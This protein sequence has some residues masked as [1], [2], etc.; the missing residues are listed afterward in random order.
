MPYGIPTRS[1]DA[2]K[3]ALHRASHSHRFTARRIFI[4][5]A[6]IITILLL[7]GVVASQLMQLSGVHAS[8]ADAPVPFHVTQPA[9]VQKSHVIG[10]A[11]SQQ[12]ISLAIGLRV[13]NEQALQAYVQD[14]THAGSVNY[15][16]Y[17][18]PAQYIGAFSPSTALYNQLEQFLQAQG[19]TVTHTYNHRLLISFSGTIAQVERTFSVNI[20]TYKAPDGHSYYANDND[21]L[22]PAWLSGNVESFSGLDDAVQLQHPLV[23]NHA[24]KQAS[25]KATANTVTCLGHDPNNQY[26]TSDQIASAYN[27][28]GMYNAGYHGEG[29]AIA[30]YEL[31]S[32]SMSD[33][34]TYESCYGHSHTNIQTFVT[35]PISPQPSNDGGI[36]EVQLDAELILSAAPQIGRLAIYEAGNNEADRLAE[37]AQIVNDA[38]PVVSTSWGLC[39]QLMDPQEIRQENTLFMSAV[40][41]GQN[42]F[43]A[44]GDSGSAGCAFDGSGIGTPP[45]GLNAGDPGAQPYVTSVG[46]TTLSLSNSG[47]YSGETTWNNPP[48]TS[49]G[50]S[51]GASG[52]GISSYWTAP[53]WQVGPGVDNSYSSSSPCAA[54]TNSSNRICR[55]TPDVSLQADPTN[56]YLVY[57]TSVQA[58][59]SGTQPW[60]AVGGTSAAAPLWAAMM[61][62]T[63]EISLQ[64]GGFNLGF[65]N[66]LMY[67][68]GNTAN[69][70]ATSFHDITSGNNDYNHLNNGLYPTTANYDMATGLGSYNALTLA[71]NLV[72]ISRSIMQARIS[73]TNTT[74]YF[75][76]GSVGG[77]FQEYITLQ[78]PSV[79]QDA[80]VNITYLFENKSAVTVSHV[81]S[82]S[83]R[84]TVSVNGDLHVQATDP[85][86]AL[87]TI[88][89]VQSGGPGIVAERPM[90]FNYKGIASGTDVVGATTPQRTYYFPSVDARNSGRTY[91]PY[92]TLLNPSSSQSANVSVTYYT[93][94]CGLS[95][96][97]ACPTQTVTLAPLHRGT[98]T[99]M[100]LNLYQQV[101]ASVQSDQA[102]V[103]E[104]PMY[105]SDNIPNAGG[106]TTGAASEVGATS[107][108]TD[109]LF[110]EGYSGPS[111]QEYLEL[112]NFGT[113]AT[114]ATV[115]L[116]YSN[117]HRQ[118]IT[119]SVPALSH[120]YFDVNQANSS[121]TGTCDTSPCQT[122]TTSSAEVTSG[123]PIVV[124]RLMYFHYG[125]GR[126]SGGTETVG[127]PGPASHSVYAFAEGYTAGSFQ[128]YLTLQNPTS[129]DETVAVTLFT[130][131]YILQQ[132]V[133]VKARSRQTVFINP[134]V[135]PI[136]TAYR[137]N[138]SDSFD[139]SLT[140]QAL[141][142]GA[143]IVAER[144]MYFN[145]YGDQ[146][147]TN[148]LGYTGG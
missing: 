127:E 36:I 104:R 141:G 40:A 94:S 53:S 60:L 145:Y 34:T 107:P 121:P 137:N 63:N 129:T 23:R 126:I 4:I 57:C 88:V 140:V 82:K 45:Q 132:Q 77:G 105:F 101:A 6:P 95:N 131:N 109:W 112:A 111:F 125:S 106:L 138:G 98:A 13:Q 8:S 55:E 123:S 52:G 122:T 61:A 59:C 30:L 37:W 91:L 35:S 86:Q 110:A 54:N 73:P 27:L 7:I 84:Q 1:G 67:Q 50:Y 32:F 142:T 48:D 148:V 90:Y 76:E 113:S 43:A 108:G 83:T 74:W 25:S 134:I 22:L 38:I 41:Q 9:V 3:R 16:R 24:I 5:A 80:T 87:S 75:A 69:Q 31:D 17:L 46:G 79:T 124:A 100:K 62:M 81:V 78:N 64:Q 119:V 15:H 144:P 103:V 146:G 89:Q 143:K 39:E 97:A 65:V 116:E 114:S 102:I 10:A 47:S 19:F 28:N 66:P 128:E 42:I 99:P 14:I 56:G 44:A 72:S 92:I 93:G 147:G 117:A 2:G 136:A 96:Q 33:L 49:T 21:P 51:G 70:Y 130:D 11:D 135:V 118:A 139:V 26:L 120:I 12:V 68:V 133:V 29:Q 58:G 85:Q 115:T 71:T 18:T 20:S